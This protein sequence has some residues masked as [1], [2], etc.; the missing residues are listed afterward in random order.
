VGVL[1][2]MREKSLNPGNGIMKIVFPFL[3]RERHGCVEEGEMGYGT[4]KIDEAVQELWGVAG[5]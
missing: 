3:E 4:S 5:C 2:W 1:P